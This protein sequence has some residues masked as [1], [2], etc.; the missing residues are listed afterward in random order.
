MAKL[1]RLSLIME[2]GSHMAVII[3]TLSLVTFGVVMIYSSSSIVAMERYG[4]EYYFLKKQLAFAVIGVLLMFVLSNLRY[5]TL[6]KVAYAG[7][8]LSV[9]LLVLILIPPIGVKKGGATR[10]LRLGFFSFQVSEFVKVALVLFMAHYLAKKIARIKE[11]SKG[12]LVP[13]VVTFMIM[14]LIM[15]QPDFGTAIIIAL[16]LM[17]MLYLAGSRILHLSALTVPFVA[18]AVI[19]V[20][21]KP[22]RLQRWLT[23]LDPW[24]DARKSGFQIIQSWI[25]FG[26]G[27]P[28]G[29]G[30]GDGMQK[31]FYLPEP[32]TDF[33]LSVVAEEV[34]FIGVAVVIAL[35]VVLVFQ[36]FVI[37]FRSTDLFGTLVAAGLTM[38]I[39][40]E[41]SINI[42]AVV[43]L[44]PTKG[45]ALPFMSYGGSSLVMSL[46]A[47]G[48]IL[49]IAASKR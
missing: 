21:M 11:F 2:K 47:V 23:F 19:L 15:L 28:F 14:G 40:L 34:G 4:D 35:F 22:Y 48:M 26:S 37:A 46:A 36:G 30:L 33:I 45:L 43:G 29:V 41:A 39:A 42:A 16:V 44:I 9:V 3:A 13:L 31:L 20:M 1:S 49:S 17:G 25:S 12:I 10:W 18:G 38:L 5:E 27:G 24:K 8:A 6:K 32:H 7:I